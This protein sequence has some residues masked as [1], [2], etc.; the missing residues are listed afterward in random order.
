M[1]NLGRHLSKFVHF[2]H[3]HFSLFATASTC[4]HGKAL[5][6]FYYAIVIFELSIS[7]ITGSFSRYVLL[8]LRLAKKFVSLRKLESYLVILQNVFLSV[9][10]CTTLG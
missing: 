5:S 3:V 10:V 7:F 8:K 6:L 1:K 9:P 4:G 2:G